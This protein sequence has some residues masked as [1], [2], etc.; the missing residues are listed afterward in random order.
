MSRVGSKGKLEKSR[1]GLQWK[2][3]HGVLVVAS[4]TFSPRELGQPERPGLGG[5]GGPMA[6][7][8]ALTRPVHLTSA[9]RI[10]HLQAL[11]PRPSVCP[12]PCI[13]T[14]HRQGT[15]FS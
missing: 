14:Q 2:P 1:D 12:L 11:L 9:L 15:L 13:F 5:G 10:L 8:G 7:Q 3:W 4:G 6:G